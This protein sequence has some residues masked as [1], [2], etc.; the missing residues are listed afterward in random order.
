VRLSI[1]KKKDLSYNRQVLSFYS[2]GGIGLIGLGETKGKLISP[3]VKFTLPSE[4]IKNVV[5]AVELEHDIPSV[6][7]E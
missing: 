6:S 1:N 4:E 7:L 3:Q 2:L 5:F